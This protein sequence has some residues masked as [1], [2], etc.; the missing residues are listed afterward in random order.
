ML[1]Q[2]WHKAC[3]SNKPV[4][5]LIEDPHHEKKRIPDIAWVTKNKRLARPGTRVK[6]DTT[7]LLKRSNKWA[8]LRLQSGK[9]HQ[10]CPPLPTSLAQEETV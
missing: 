8:L 4:S 3:R 1:A 9:D 2:W 7:A 10:Y 6:S 5:A